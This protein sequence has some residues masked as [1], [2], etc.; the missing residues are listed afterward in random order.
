[1]YTPLNN[2]FEASGIGAYD[3][4]G[5]WA[6]EYYPP[7]YDFLAPANSVAMPPPVLRSGVGDCGCGCN[8]AGACGGGHHH[9]MGL[10]DSM[11]ISTWGVGEWGIVALGLYLV[12]SL[13]G[14]TKRATKKI[15]KVTRRRV[16]TQRV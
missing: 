13:M 5:N 16:R 3:H 14:D 9:G 15:R 6:W 8:G 7:P 4:T 11:D 2:R 12:G 1:M 10:F